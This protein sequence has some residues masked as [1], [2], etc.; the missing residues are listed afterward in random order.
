MTSLVVIGYQ[1]LFGIK[2]T[3]QEDITTPKSLLKLT[4]RKLGGVVL[5]AALFQILSP[6]IDPYLTSGLISLVSWLLQKDVTILKNTDYG[7]ALAAIIGVGGVFIG[8]YY[9]AISTVCSAIYADKPNNIRNLL[10]LDRVSS[11]YMDLLVLLTSFGVCLLAIHVLGGEPAI[12]A[13]LLLLFGAGWMIVGFIQLGRRAF[14]LFDPTTLAEPI[15]KQLESCW[16]QI[17]TNSRCWSDQNLQTKYH[18]DA[19]EA[20]DTFTTLSDLTAEAKHLNGRPFADLC[21]NL[22]SFL[23]DYE[24]AKKSIPTN[25][26]WYRQ[27]YVYPDQY[28]T[29]HTEISSNHQSTTGID[30]KP[31]SDSRWLE[32]DMLPIVKCC[33]QINIRNKRYEIVKELLDGINNY[34]QQLVEE[35]QVEPA[36]KLIR[37]MFS[38][39]EEVILFKKD[40]AVV[41]EPLEHMEI[42]KRLAEIPIN[43]LIA[44]THTIKLSGPDAILARIDRVV[45]KSRQSIY[46]TGFAWHVLEQLEWL[47]PRLMF[48]ERVEGHIITETWYIQELIAQKEAENLRTAMTCFYEKA[49]KLY[50]HWIEIA[51][52]QH[53]W[54]AAQ[55]ISVEVKYWNSLDDHIPILEHLWNN[56]NSNQNRKNNTVKFDINE[57]IKKEKQRKKEL[58]RLMA[59]EDILFSLTPRPASYPD[60]AGQFLSNVGNA[61]LTA[62]Y[63]NDRDTV[64]ELFKSYFRGS[65]LEFEKLKSEE[66]GSDWRR[67]TDTKT[68]VSPLLDL[69]DMSGYAYLLS[70]YHDAPCLKNPIVKTWND[71]RDQPSII[72]ILRFFAI[73]ISFSESVFGTTPRDLNRTRWKQ[74]IQQRLKDVERQEIPPTPG[75]KTVQT[76][77][78]TV[79]VHQSPLVIIFARDPS[80]SHWDGIDIFISEYVRKLEDGE[81]I[82]FGRLRR[83]DLR[84]EI[85]RVERHAAKNE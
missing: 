22:L 77:R 19:Q 23:I 18:K 36:F 81:N 5:I 83:R 17:Q 62:M 13:M 68:A 59:H 61:L 2:S 26:L 51:T 76:E 78:D 8:L 74:M 84:E 72:P 3:I 69:I 75:R 45:W 35:Q 44:Y 79:P 41:E 12:L 7:T 29:Y 67:R 65:L 21:K 14:N 24:K 1:K 40:E 60:F 54:L 73:T 33:L 31:V 4:L 66:T 55:A 49:G 10:A 15:F 37:E 53:P 16:T 25:S 56:L 71:Y 38:S 34:V 27:Q 50:R 47:R 57:E 58:F 85:R 30:P 52:S 63:Q 80:S 82:D 48:E 28:R 6:Y 20:I 32:S 9:A 64:E 42:C 43:V 70:D 46:N 39:C 11:F